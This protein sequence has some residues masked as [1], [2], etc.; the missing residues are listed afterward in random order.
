MIS[1]VLVEPETPGNIGA[2]A[3][4]MKNFGLKDLVIINPKCNHL[5]DESLFRAT[6]AKEILKKAKVKKHDYLSRFDYCIG[7]TAIIGSDYNIPRSPLTPELLAEKISEKKSK[8]A[9][10]FGREGT[11]LTNKEIL[12]CDFIVTIPAS[13]K[14]PT[15]NL[16]HAS[17]IIFY[18]LF[19][20]N[21]LKSNSHII[22]ASKKEKDVLD[23]YISK[24]LDK[25]EFSTKEKRDTQK[26]VWKRII[27]KSLMTK[28]ELFAVIGFFKKLR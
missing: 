3:R 24:Q 19:K 9:L 26:R 28:R 27:G 12:K 16:S 17:A 15:L 2:I 4:S 14:Y 8:F 7:T 21:K 10:I 25:M 13:K 1:V 5:D 20:K 18:E 11:G 22:T 6:H 23:H